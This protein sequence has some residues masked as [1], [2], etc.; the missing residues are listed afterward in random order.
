MVRNINQAAQLEGAIEVL[1][2]LWGSKLQP[3]DKGL[4]EDFFINEIGLKLCDFCHDWIAGSDR[5]T[6]TGLCRECYG[7]YS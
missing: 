2:E 6:T 1:K 5:D 3:R 7:K 4:I